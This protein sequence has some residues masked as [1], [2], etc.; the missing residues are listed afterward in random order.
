MESIEFKGPFTFEGKDSI[1]EVDSNVNVN[2]VYLW[3]VKSDTDLFRVYYV[4][5]S[6]DIKRRLHDHLIK[7]R[8]GLYSGHCIESLKNNIKILMHRPEK[9]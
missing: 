4:G 7:Q 5:E 6:K 8:N 9:K 2:G 1:F 3:C